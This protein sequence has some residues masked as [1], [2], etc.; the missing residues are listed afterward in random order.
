MAAET[1]TAARASATFPVA[2]SGPAQNVKVGWG[3][4]AIAA[5]LE[6]GDIFEMHWVPDGATVL[7]GWTIAGDL[8]TGTEAIDIDLGWAA[9]S[10]DSA[11]PDGFGNLGVW[12]GDTSVHLGGALNYFPHQGVIVTAGPKTYTT[13]GGA[14]KIQLEANAAAGTFAAAQATVVT[15]YTAP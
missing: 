7:G 12:T 15:F 6:D 10:E 8:D 4:Y 11:D 2:G 1:L 9:N 3:T 14:T 5:D 13:G